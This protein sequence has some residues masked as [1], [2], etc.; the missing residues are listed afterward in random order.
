MENSLSAG[1]KARL[2]HWGSI[3]TLG[4]YLLAILEIAFM[5]TPFAAYYYTAYSPVLSVV[6][7]SRYTSW[8]S[9]FFVTHLSVP[10]S[11]FLVAI[12]TSGVILAC[13]GVAVFLVHAVYLYWLK[14]ARNAVAT[15]LLYAYVRHPQY[16]SLMVAGLGLAIMWP[17]FINLLLFLAMTLAYNALARHEERRLMAK[18]PVDYQGYMERKSRF[19]PG[20]PATYLN[21]LFVWLPEGRTRTTA[22]TVAVFTITIIAAFALRFYSV[23]KLKAHLHPGSPGALVIALDPPD[24]DDYQ[25]SAREAGQ[26]AL[27][28]SNARPAPT[29]LILIWETRRLRHFLIDSGFHEDVFD[30]L[31]IPPTGI[32]LIEASVHQPG[33][34]HGP[35]RIGEPN[36]ATRLTVIRR[37]ERIHHRL[38][39]S[40]SPSW[41]E[42]S[43]P[44]DS[45]HF[46]ASLPIL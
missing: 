15:R 14:F 22:A 32:F 19:L 8:L 13:L 40:A 11:I 25:R 20:N 43:I 36:Q 24:G 35:T 7:R 26:Y 16:S 31:E 3:A 34:A 12:K 41:T 42:I 21:R 45:L 9:E 33:V 37:L 30:E 6:S 1:L 17:R 28:S 5:S 46:H 2:S 4:V 10:D 38:Q 39:D 44:V 18:H 27:A 23:A 29:L